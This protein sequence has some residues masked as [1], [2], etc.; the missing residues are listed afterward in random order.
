MKALITGITGFVGRHLAEYLLA[1]GMEVWGTTRSSSSNLSLKQD[2]HIVQTGLD[3][4]VEIISMLNQIRPDHIYHLAGQSSVKLSWE[5]KAE[6]FEANVTKTIHLL[7]AIRKSD[8]A[9]T[10]RI[11]T[12]GSSE[13]Y[14]KVDL[15]EMPIKETTPLRPISPYGIS[16]ATVSMVAQHYYNAYRLKIIHA[17]P[18]NHIGPGQGLGFVTSDFA[19]QIVEIEQL[20]RAPVISVGN[21]TSKRDFMDVRDIIVA[22]KILLETK[23]YGE[24]YNVCSGSPVG[25]NDILNYLLSHSYTSNINLELDPGRKRPSD[26][27]LYFGENNKIKNSTNWNKTI[28][29]EKSILD[30][31]NYWRKMKQHS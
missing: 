14:G 4:E 11:L 24:V 5:K 3:N 28:G 20:K 31:L 13:E 2:V 6:T 26:L 17:R 7:E 12:V 19:K 25:I 22:Y 29:I 27:P 16:K 23:S 9:E 30:I 18:F 21:L 15:D 8:I 1:E 10:V